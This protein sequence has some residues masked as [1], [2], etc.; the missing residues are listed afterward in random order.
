[1]RLLRLGVLLTIATTPSTVN[2]LEYQTPTCNVALNTCSNSSGTPL[3]SLIAT[4]AD[5]N[6]TVVVPC[7]A[8][9]YVDI[10]DGSTVDLPYG[11]DIVGR[12]MF[13]PSANLE[14]KTTSVIVQGMMDIPRLDTGNKITFNMYGTEDVYYYPHDECNGSYDP[15]CEHRK[16]VG[17]KPIVVA[18]GKM[19]IEAV[20]TSC[21]SWTK[22]KY[23]AGD[24]LLML[25]S[26]FASC[27]KVGDDILVTSSTT[28]WYDDQQSKITAIEHFSHGSVVTIDTAIIESLPGTDGTI[29]P[30]CQ[31]G[32]LDATSTTCCASSCGSCGGSGCSGRPGG[33]SNCC[34][35]SIGRSGKICSDP[36]QSSCRLDEGSEMMVEDEGY[37]VEVAS[38]SRNVV[39]TADGDGEDH[40][41]GHFIV[42]HTSAEQMISGVRFDNFGQGKRDDE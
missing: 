41:G 20:D 32:V 17:M 30:P 1:M 2:A 36:F 21:P 34:T 40:H 19:N 24:D 12:L 9:A 38:L 8:C 14:I 22:L 7:N 37:A 25:D 6:T 15:S 26:E 35:G 16:N 39:F 31:K 10:T 33:A 29:I 28:K 23:K 3:S 5:N 42:F 27:L 13:P 4:A 11:I 18:G